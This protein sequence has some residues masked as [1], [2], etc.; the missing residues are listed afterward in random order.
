M[1]ELRRRPI[2]PRPAS[3]SKPF[4]LNIYTIRLKLIKGPCRFKSQLKKLFKN[5]RHLFMQPP[6]GMATLNANLFHG[7][8]DV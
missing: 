4:H 8:G 2:R 1:K 6:T 3:T 5:R 7:G